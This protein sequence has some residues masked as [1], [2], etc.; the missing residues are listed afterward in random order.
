MINFNQSFDLGYNETQDALSIRIEA[1]KRFSNF[2]LEDWLDERFPVKSG[3]IILDIGCGSGNFFPLYSKKIGDHGAIVGIDQSCNLLSEA[4]KCECNTPR[5]LLKWNMNNRFPFMD[6]SFDYIISSFAIYYVNETE[7]I[8][9][10][11]KRLLKPKGEVFLIGPTDRNA[12]ELYEYNKMVFGFDED[13]RIDKRTNRLEHEFYPGMETI[14]GNSNIEKIPSKLIFPNKTE[15]IRYYM[16]TLLYEESIKKA[17]LKPDA[18]EL[19]SVK[20]LSYEISKEMIM[21]Q[22]KKNE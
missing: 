1:H 21:L 6:N 13:E 20:M 16:A 17:C 11:I 2:S 19:F 14:F 9:K 22:S 5:I 8:I 15:F 4:M 12:R 10:E 7:P 18:K 3:N